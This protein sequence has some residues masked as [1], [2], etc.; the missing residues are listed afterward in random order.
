MTTGDS[1]RSVLTLQLV[2]MLGFSAVVPFVAA[3]GQH[4]FALDASAVGILVGARVLAQQGLFIVGGLLTDRFG[5]RAL[6]LAGCLLRALAFG[7]IAWAPHAPAFVVGVVLV[8]LAGA[9]FSPAVDALVGRIDARRRRAA[10]HGIR[11]GPTPFAALLMVSELGGVI[12]ALGAA[13]VMPEHSSAVAAFSAVIFLG[14]AAAVLR[15]SSAAVET[16]PGPRS[17]DSGAPGTSARASARAPEGTSGPQLGVRVLPLAI[18]CSALLAVYAQLFS[19]VPLALADHGLPPGHMGAVAASLSAATLV[20]QWPLSRA[21]ERIGR[22]TAV[23]L[24]LGLSAAACLCAFAGQ[25]LLP[26]GALTGLLCGVAVLVG[27][28]LM[29]GNPSAQSLIAEG[30]G[31]RRATRLALVPTAGGVAA[32]LSTTVTGVVS[33]SANTSAA[34]PVAA[35]LPAVMMPLAWYALGLGSRHH[36]RHRHPAQFSPSG[37]PAPPAPS[38]AASAGAPN[39]HSPNAH[40][41][42]THPSTTKEHTQ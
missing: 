22:G 21:A 9:L 19:T 26:S 2:F 36:R 24:A 35:V 29:L 11:R 16:Q 20:L 15:L 4:R 42:T 7:V 30:S 6:L 33:G 10:D 13:R 40:P 3:I 23:M 27:A 8:G 31:R 34:W 37:P 12:A 17:R 41:S 39:P 5:P 18:A 25:L 32:F 38:L 28:S 1:L 14:A